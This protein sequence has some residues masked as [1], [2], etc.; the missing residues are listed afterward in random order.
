M[1]TEGKKLI[2]IFNW[3]MKG[4]LMYHDWHFRTQFSQLFLPKHLF[5]LNVTLRNMAFSNNIRKVDI[6]FTE[7]LSY[8]L[9]CDPKLLCLENAPQHR[10][11]SLS[12]FLYHQHLLVYP[13]DRN[14][15]WNPLRMS[16]TS[17]KNTKSP[18]PLKK[19]GCLVTAEQQMKRGKSTNPRVMAIPKLATINPN[20]RLSVSSRS[21]W[22]A[23]LLMLPNCVALRHVYLELRPE[24]ERPEL[25]RK[26]ISLKKAFLENSIRFARLFCVHYLIFH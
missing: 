26:I 11:W 14:P 24:D 16:P 21:S 10:L 23:F 20:L 18:T 19:R 5:S 15:E 12:W 8:Y 17:I 1:K 9:G 22:W 2:T 4:W 6:S 13:K 3:Y 7:G 25:L